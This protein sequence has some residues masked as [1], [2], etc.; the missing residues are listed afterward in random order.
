M[1]PPENMTPPDGGAGRQRL[2]RA[3]A[4]LR[5]LASPPVLLATTAILVVILYGRLLGRSFWV[6]EAGT[7]WM[8]HEGPLAAPLVNTQ[9]RPSM[10][11]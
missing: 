2:T 8:A 6:D 7:F 1:I 11:T 4:A 3:D 5:A 10:I 9:N